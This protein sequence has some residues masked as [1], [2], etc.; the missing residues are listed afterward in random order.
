LKGAINTLGCDRDPIP[1]AELGHR[2]LCAGRPN[3]RSVRLPLE[4][5]RHANFARRCFSDRPVFL[6]LGGQGESP[7]LRTSVRIHWDSSRLNILKRDK[8]RVQ[9]APFVFLGER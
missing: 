9:H 3:R 7:D 2:L 6:D 8:A 5:A 4:V 1:L